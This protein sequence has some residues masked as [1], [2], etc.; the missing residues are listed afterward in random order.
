MSPLPCS[1]GRKTTTP[2]ANAQESVLAESA[3]MIPET[4]AR[5]EAALSD[6]QGFVGEN[7]GDAAGSGELDAAQAAIAE[8][9]GIF[10]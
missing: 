2:G 9:R 1:P 4:R 7:D 5:L 8:A 3:M 6:L 10:G